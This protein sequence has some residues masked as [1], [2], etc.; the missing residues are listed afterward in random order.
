MAGARQGRLAALRASIGRLEGGGGT[1]ARVTLG[2]AG[3][4]AALQGGLARGAI[5]E[6][7]AGRACDNPAA[8]GFLVGLACRVMRQRPVLWVRQDFAAH[9][10]GGVAM[11][12]LAEAGFD[13]RRLV[14]VR[15]GDVEAALRVAADALGCDALGAVVLEIWGETRRLDQLASR[16]LTLAAQQ[17]GV[18]GLLLR[19]SA[20]PS[21]GTSETRWVVH[22]ARSPPGP[23]QVAWGAPLFEACLVRNRHGPTGRWIMEWN[24]DECLFREPA[25]HSQPVAAASFDRPLETFGGA[26]RR[27][28]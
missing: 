23:D 2:H 15:A 22:A 20:A 13:P 26:T 21:L 3:A 8:T 16:K 4:D 24:C 9:E 19:T 25:A 7:F 28:G 6:V 17:S 27:A 5:H 1:A 10:Y 11:A 18:T 14:L 12:G